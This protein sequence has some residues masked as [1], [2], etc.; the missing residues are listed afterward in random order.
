VSYT[1][2]SVYLFITGTSLPENEVTLTDMSQPA[3]Q[4]KFTQIDLNCNQEWSFRWDT[5]RIG[6]EMN[7]GTYQVYVTNEPVNKAHLGGSN[8]CKTLEVSLKESTTSR[9]SV[10]SGVT[11]TLRPGMQSSVQVPMLAITSPTPIPTPL[12]TPS[13]ADPAPSHP[14]TKASLIPAPVFLTVLV[15]AGTATLKMM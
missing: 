13:T 4:G 10:G 1:G 5:S 12:I 8:S 9:V 15:V 6:N 7:A 2:G 11:Y 3:D 14:T